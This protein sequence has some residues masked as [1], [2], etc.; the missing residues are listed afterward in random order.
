MLNPMLNHYL[1]TP[2]SEVVLSP[3]LLRSSISHLL[4]EHGAW[5]VLWDE[6]PTLIAHFIAAQAGPL[7][8]AIVQQS[9]RAQFMLP[10]QVVVELRPDG[11]GEI[12]YVPS[13][14]RAQFL[15][16]LVDPIAYGDLGKVVSRRL[17]ELEQ[18][19]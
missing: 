8:E 1:H 11:L 16:G 5:H 6:Q 15:G 2:S 18:S 13:S 3:Q 9:L 17:A 12:G 14:A 19:S 4:E 7:A 10:D